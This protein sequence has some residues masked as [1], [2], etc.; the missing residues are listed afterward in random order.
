MP[1]AKSDDDVMLI[2]AVSS[3][4]D[5]ISVSTN[6]DMLSQLVRTQA[7][8]PIDICFKE[9]CAK[10]VVHMSKYVRCIFYIAY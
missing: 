2:T 6:V 4:L 9:Q 1:N 5:E 10:Q 8:K 3:S 7:C